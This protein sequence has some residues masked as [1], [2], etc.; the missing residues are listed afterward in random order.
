MSNVLIRVSEIAARAAERPAGYYES[1]MA[2]GTRVADDVIAVPL[3]SYKRLA[4][5]YAPPPP[6]GP[7]SELAKLL[8]NWLGIQSTPNCSC[9][10]RASQ[11]DAWGPDECERRLEEIL[12]WLAE[13]SQKRGLPFVRMAARQMVR[14]AIRKARKSAAQ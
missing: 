12:D 3:D 2:V 8:H 10:S 9:A 13:E 6:G 1:V 5:Q 7:G 14:L 11:M 4:A